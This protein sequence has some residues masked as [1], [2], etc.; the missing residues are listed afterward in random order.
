MKS[1]QPFSPH[2][3]P[4][5]PALFLVLAAAST[6]VPLPPVV[7][8]ASAAASALPA[9]ASTAISLF[10]A[11]FPALRQ[12]LRTTFLPYPAGSASS[13]RAPKS[14]SVLLPP[15]AALHDAPRCRKETRHD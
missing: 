15:G 4:A 9:P 11:K 1:P 5:A 2:Q 12:S 14:S 6:P 10:P 13:G 3:N 8:K 7:C